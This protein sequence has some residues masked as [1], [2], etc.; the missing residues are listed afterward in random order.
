[1]QYGHSAQVASGLGGGNCG[2]PCSTGSLGAGEGSTA[3]TSPEKP[4]VDNA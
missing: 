4:N 3:A 1:M 2:E